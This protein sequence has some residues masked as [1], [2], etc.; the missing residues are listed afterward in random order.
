MFVI[1]WEYEVKSGCE[2]SFESAYSTAGPWVRLFQRDPRFLHTRLL[3]D[4]T[5][6]RFYFTL[7]Y[8]ESESAFR[9][10]KQ[11]NQAAYSEIDKLCDGLTLSERLLTNFQ[12][13]T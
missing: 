1:L 3:R 10:F 4:L 8:W 13:Q 2:E 5:R 6:S 9:Q 7:D 11:E 12:S